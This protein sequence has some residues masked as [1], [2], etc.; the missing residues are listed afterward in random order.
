MVKIPVRMDDGRLMVF[1]G[2]RVQ[3]NNA[4][5]P[6]KGG[7]KYHPEVTLE[8]DIALAMGMTLK[9][10]LAG[11]PDILANADGVIMSYLE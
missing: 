7:I 11:I 3:H 5:G 8:T 9:N 4:L 1:E 6:Y 2:Y 10:S